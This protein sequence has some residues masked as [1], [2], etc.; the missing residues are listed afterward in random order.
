MTDLT[1]RKIIAWMLVIIISLFFISGILST[2]F[3]CS[4][5]LTSF[6]HV[7]TAICVCSLFGGLCVFY[8]FLIIIEIYDMITGE[9]DD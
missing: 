1:K 9:R 3:P 2:I 4:N 6:N 5:F 7:Y 8:I